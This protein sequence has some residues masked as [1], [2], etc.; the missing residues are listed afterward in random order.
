MLQASP[1]FQPLLSFSPEQARASCPACA[2]TGQGAEAARRPRFP[3][4]LILQTHTHTEICVC[5]SRWDAGASWHRVPRPL[6]SAAGACGF[7]DDQWCPRCT[8]TERHGHGEPLPIAPSWRGRCWV[9]RAGRVRSAGRGRVC[10]RGHFC[11]LTLTR[12]FSPKCSSP[13]DLS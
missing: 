13:C 8:G 10:S 6:C 5:T 1:P 9:P 4:N 12:S 2:G 7:A 11:T 3:A